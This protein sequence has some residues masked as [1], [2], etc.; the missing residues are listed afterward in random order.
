VKR[1]EKKGSKDN[2]IFCGIDK[3]GFVWPIYIEDPHLYKTM[4][5]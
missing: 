2:S 5:T 4:A 3:V 1:K